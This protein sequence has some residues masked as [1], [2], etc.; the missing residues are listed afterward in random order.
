MLT[1]I[2]IDN[3]LN[4]QEYL[5]NLIDKY[6]SSQIH[7]F[8]IVSTIAEG[9][10]LI[11]S[12]NPDIIFLDIEMSEENEFKFFEYFNG[13]GNFEAVFTTA[14]KKYA[15]SAIKNDA[16]DFL[17]KPIDK[18]DLLSLI[19]KYEKKI[20]ERKKNNSSVFDFKNNNL[21]KIPLPT[22][23]GIKYIDEYMFLYAKADGSYSEINTI[24]G[25][26]ITLS[27]SLKEFEAM[28]NNY[29]FFRVHKS[30]IINLLHVSELIKKDEYFILLKNNIKIPLSI[31]RKDEFM[32]KIS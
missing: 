14:H 27:K 32:S 28:T 22:L 24:D 17:I 12:L 9:V 13:E 30:Y 5:K 26:T 8:G 7:I 2:I 10:K 29:N 25:K 21:P 3:E 18:I 20:Q 16:F 31:R 11:K 6:F 19:K 15:T 23:Y 1:A 4:S